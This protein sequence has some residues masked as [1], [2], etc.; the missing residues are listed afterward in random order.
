MHTFFIIK[1]FSATTG[2]LLFVKVYNTFSTPQGCP[3]PRTTTQPNQVQATPKFKLEPW[4]EGE[5]GPT[6]CR[7]G[8]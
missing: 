4:Q 6:L 3:L 1:M 2:P 8:L 5:V 7:Q